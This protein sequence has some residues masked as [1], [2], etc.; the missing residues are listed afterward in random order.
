DRSG[1]RIAA[2]AP[3]D[4]L[5]LDWQRLSAE[6]VEPDVPP[7][8]LMLARARNEY[9]DNLIVG[10]REVVRQGMVT[11]VELPRLENE[12]LRELR[13]ARS[14]TDDLRAALPELKAATRAYYREPFYC[15]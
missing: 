13:A 11:G 10:G 15:A 4:I 7:I 1:G 9:V 12:L 3:A 5:V 14:S 2:G 6:L 8:E